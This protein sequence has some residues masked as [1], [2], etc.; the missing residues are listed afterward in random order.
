VSLVASLSQPKKVRLVRSRVVR[1]LTAG[2]TRDPVG[3]FLEEAATARLSLFCT[4]SYR[5]FLFDA[6]RR[7]IGRDGKLRATDA[8]WHWF[9]KIRHEVRFRERMREHAEAQEPER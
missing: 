3:V 8:Q 7:W 2:S 5:K 1:V 9:N 4:H 6:E